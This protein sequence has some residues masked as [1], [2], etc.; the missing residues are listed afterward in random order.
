M[1]RPRARALPRRERSGFVHTP[2][3]QLPTERRHE[4]SEILYDIRMEVAAWRVEHGVPEGTRVTLGQMPDSVLLKIHS[5]LP[6]VIEKMI[7]NTGG[8]PRREGPLAP[9]W[10]REKS[11]PRLDWRRR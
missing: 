8:D 6:W 2:F 11:P 4:I 10:P 7:W 5:I 1:A 9:F 3:I